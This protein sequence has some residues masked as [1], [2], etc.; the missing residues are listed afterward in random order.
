[1][2]GCPLGT[3]KTK[4]E[5]KRVMLEKF[6]IRRMGCSDDAEGCFFFN[7]INLSTPGLL[8]LFPC[9]KKRVLEVYIC[10]FRSYE[11][12]LIL[13]FLVSHDFMDFSDKIAYN[14]NKLMNR[15]I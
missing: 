8:P 7:S 15:R 9:T 12:I 6:L 4:K 11:R 5:K 2:M 3:P 14:K 1:M 10:F 13:L